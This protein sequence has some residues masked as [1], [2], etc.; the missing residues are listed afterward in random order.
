[1][2]MLSGL[3]A[4]GSGVATGVAWWAHIGGFVAGLLVATV[5]GRN[6][7]SEHAVHEHRF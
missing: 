6:R 2:Q 3:S 1:M 5:L 7:Y 4:V